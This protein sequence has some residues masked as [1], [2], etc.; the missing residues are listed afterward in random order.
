M[1]C[2]MPFLYEGL[3]HPRILV[4]VGSWNQCPGDTEGRLE[5]KVTSGFS[6]SR[7]VTLTLSVV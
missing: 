6:T 4:S 7:E 2:S 3:E 1:N 5:S